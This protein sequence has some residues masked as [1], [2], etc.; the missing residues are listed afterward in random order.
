MVEKIENVKTPLPSAVDL[1]YTMNRQQEIRHLMSSTS[2]M[3]QVS[4]NL[5]NGDLLRGGG[6][7]SLPG[8]VG[9]IQDA[10]VR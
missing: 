9:R 6:Q 5:K 3:A 2:K 7:L 10:P 1:A 8:R 4:H